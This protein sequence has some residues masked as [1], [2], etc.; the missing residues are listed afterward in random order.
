MI[1][2][3]VRDPSQ[4]AEARR[5]A[6]RAAEA[7]GFAAAPAGQVALAATELA[8]NLLKHGGGGQLLV[9]ASAAHADLL[10]LDRGPGMADVR[11]CLADGFSTAGTLGHGLGAVRRLSSRLE[12]ASWPGQ[13]T[14]VWAR[15]VPTIGPV[16]AQAGPPLQPPA[17]GGHAPA[18]LSVPKPGES[19][20][21]DAW[22]SH[23][24]AQGHTLFM[25]DGLGH[26]PD[27][28]LAASEAVRQF[29]LSRDA[30]PD[31]IVHA[32][33]RALRPTRGGAVAA[34][35]IDWRRRCVVFAGLGNIAGAVVARS[36]ETRR[37]VSH[38]GTAGHNARKIQA[39]EYPA[40]DSMLVMHSDGVGTH[41]ALDRYAGLLNAHPMLVAAVL[42][43]DHARGRDD[44]TVLACPTDPPGPP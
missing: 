8:T 33:H 4:V 1:Q 19:V 12:I 44:A 42:Y 41:W 43:R 21:G 9:E 26:G 35:R 5:C 23:T 15:V 38:N 13:G 3:E 24:D 20:C 36:G 25:V 22:S 6:L 27:A 2:T 39:F 17:A 14:A 37:M 28:A 30:P 7:A 32:V 40:S 34:A 11:G 10:A 16:L 18:A 31:A 29:L